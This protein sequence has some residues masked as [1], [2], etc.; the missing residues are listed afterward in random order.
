MNFNPYRVDIDY[1]TGAKS[2][3]IRPFFSIL[4]LTPDHGANWCSAV[5]K[6]WVFLR[7]SRVRRSNFVQYLGSHG[8][9]PSFSIT[10]TADSS[11]IVVKNSCRPEKA[12]IFRT[13]VLL[14][15]QN[16]LLSVES[17]RQKNKLL[18]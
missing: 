14:G 9:Q 6:Q 5:R 8:D 16:S 7:I 18:A 17:D 2:A 3:A 10:R 15:D 12:K 13:T 4:K 11:R 1:L